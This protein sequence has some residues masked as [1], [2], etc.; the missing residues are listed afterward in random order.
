[1]TLTGKNCKAGHKPCVLGAK[2]D[3]EQ[4]RSKG[5]LSFQGINNPLAN[6]KGPVPILYIL[7]GLPVFLREV[8]KNLNAYIHTYICILFFSFN[9][10]FCLNC[11]NR[12]GVF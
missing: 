8:T 12:R 10:I 6:C 3:K 9:S 5:C 7:E 1:M 4:G 2:Q 11:L